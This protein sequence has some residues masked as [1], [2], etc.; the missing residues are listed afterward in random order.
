MTVANQPLVVLPQQRSEFDRLCQ[1]EPRLSDLFDRARSLYEQATRTTSPRPWLS[2]EKFVGRE[3]YRTA[4][5]P[6]RPL[7]GKHDAHDAT[8]GD[9]VKQQMCKLVGWG[10][11][12]DADPTLKTSEAYDV[13]YAILYNQLCG[14]APPDP[15]A[16]A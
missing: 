4:A 14:F 1:L 6:R 15:R 13:A 8:G 11:P 5:L 3:W 7:A 10:A 12:E 2:L 16:R 9:G